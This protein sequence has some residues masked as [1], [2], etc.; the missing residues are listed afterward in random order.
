[1]TNA[2][3][4]Y[5]HQLKAVQELGN[6]KVLWGGTGSGKS[7]VAAAYYIERGDLK[8]VYVI[9]TAKKR[10]SLDWET[11][12]VRYGVYKTRDST[13]AGVLTV[14]SWNNIEKYK[15]VTDAFFIFDEQRIV[16]S[17][18]W[19][20][21]FIKIAKK[22]RWILCTATPGDT[23]IDYIPIFVANGFYKNRTEF[24]REHVIYSYFG[25][26]PKIERYVGVGKLI[27]LR[28]SLLV[29][30]PYVQ[31]TTRNVKRVEVEYNTQ[32]MEEVTKKRWHVFENRPLRDAGELYSVA[33][34]VVNS[35]RTRLDSL[36][37][38]LLTHPKLIVFYNFDYEL[39]ILRELAEDATLAEW[40][41]H[42]HQ[43]VPDNDS[44][45]YLV[46]YTAGSEGWNCTS[47]DAMVLYSLPYSYKSWHQAFGRIDRLNTPYEQLYYY[48]LRSTSWIDN[49]VWK[50]LS[51]KKSFNE[52]AYKVEF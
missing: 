9:T 34:K 40:N 49:A 50:S 16:G 6:G 44:W 10:D 17:G 30:M 37:T 1:M 28:N 39:E 11:E 3:D 15:D 24:K 36:R 23:W 41:G 42:K 22:N 29:E 32:Q 47:T 45:I 19:S 7:R 51:S 8:D 38:L 13:V 48:I 27:R 21:Y 35:D 12:F 20:S 14:D 33:R 52:S 18:A 43:P 31:H 4:L 2:V 25:K 46:Q 5:P 26:F